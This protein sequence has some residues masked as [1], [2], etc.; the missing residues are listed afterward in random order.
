M[1]VTVRDHQRRMIYH[2]PQTPGYTCWAGIW[3]MPDGSVMV[4]FTQVTGPLQG[5]RQRAPQDILRRMP[6]AQQENPTYDFTGL[7]QENVYLRSTDGG[8]TWTK[9]ASD[10]FSSCL[11]G[12]CEGGVVVLADG[13][14]LRQAWGQSLTYC[15]VRSTGFVQRSTDGARTWGPPEYLS[16]DPHL[17]TFPTRIR[18]LRDGRIIVTGGAAPYD[19]DNWNWIALLP[20]CRHCLWVSKDPAG[21]AWEGP[22]Y[23]VP[24]SANCRCEEWDAAELGNGDLLAVLRTQTYDAAGNCTGQARHQTILAKRGDTW[25]PGP[26]QPAPFPHSGHPELLATREGVILHVASSGISWTADRGTTWTTLDCPGTAYYPHAVQLDD[27]AILAV[28]HIGSDDPYGKTD[29]AIVLDRLRLTVD[30]ERAE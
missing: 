30:R 25:E 21:R 9:V 6:P 17:Q 13:T 7:C 3:Q 23:I 8:E 15:D 28:S 14:L 29:Q 20:K 26:I 18:R 19:P 5:W 4:S 11:N 10:T 24:E 16:D 2:S 27:G 22:L 1:H 12:Y